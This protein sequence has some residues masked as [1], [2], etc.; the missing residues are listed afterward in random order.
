MDVIWGGTLS[1]T[2]QGKKEYLGAR[3]DWRSVKR[4]VGKGLSF[5]PRRWGVGL[6]L[7]KSHHPGCQGGEGR[8]GEE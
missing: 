3:K 2:L 5:E 7:P 6:V 4:M 1:D 8:R